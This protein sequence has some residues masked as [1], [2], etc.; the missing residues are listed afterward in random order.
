MKP[1]STKLLAL[2][3]TVL[4]GDRYQHIH[5]TE[6][7]ACAGRSQSDYP[8]LLDAIK[9]NNGIMN[10]VRSSIHESRTDAQKDRVEKIGQFIEIAKVSIGHVCRIWLLLMTIFRL[11][12]GM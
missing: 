8:N 2:A 7:I 1:M 3:L 12:V 6:Y 9:L 5:A 11:R 10:W 4:E